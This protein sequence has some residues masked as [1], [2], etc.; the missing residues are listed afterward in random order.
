MKMG[1]DLPFAVAGGGLGNWAAPALQ[2]EGGGVVGGYDAAAAEG[3]A[4]EDGSGSEF[5]SCCIM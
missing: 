3:G 1:W 2:A 5:G 4:E